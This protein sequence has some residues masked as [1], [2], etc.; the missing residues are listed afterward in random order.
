MPHLLLHTQGCLP[1]QRVILTAAADPIAK[2]FELKPEM[3]IDPEHLTCS[4]Y[5]LSA[6][7][8]FST[9]VIWPMLHKKEQRSRHTH[10]INDSGSLITDYWQ[11]QQP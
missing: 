8:C 9:D 5:R 2:L 3:H 10:L 4:T 1:G 7:G 11:P 6:S